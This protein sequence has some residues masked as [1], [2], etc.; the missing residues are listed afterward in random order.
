MTLVLTGHF[1][2]DHGGVERFSL[3]L[4]KRLPPDRIV[5]VAP[6]VS[7]AAEFDDGLDFPVV[8]YRGR[9]T[10]NPRLTATITATM[11]RF[12]CEQAWLT[13]GMPLG[14]MAGVVRRGGA[15]RVVI[16]THGL[17]AGWAALPGVRQLMQLA[18]RQADVLTYLTPYTRTRLSPLIEPDR[19][20]QLT[21]GADADQPPAAADGAALRERL[22][23]DGR[24][25]VVSVSRLV[26]RKGQDML[27]HAWGQLRSA[28]P[29]AALLI[30]G[31][32]YYGRQLRRLARRLGVAD[33]VMFVG[34]VRDDELPSYLAAADVYA[35][36]CRTQLGGMLV[37][38]LGLTTLEA[39]A[40]GLPV[41]VGDSGGAAEAV[42]DGVTGR[43]VPTRRRRKGWDVPGLAGVLDELLGDAA[44]R[45]AMGAA[46]RD[47]VREC[48]SWDAMAG[49]LGALLCG[50]PVRR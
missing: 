26:P 31:D 3:E 6:D 14:A 40:Q 49:R 12:D 27:L 42:I 37:E 50:A 15:R 39:S 24:P 35:L 16:S 46:G 9:V 45:A 21:G 36:P 5:V 38:G 41:V 10:T 20:V 23:L 11:R 32:G 2:P 8:R 1:P 43:V 29:G 22:G 13:S 7:G 47:W 44:L 19:L 25:V 34:A 30:V 18:A 33:S 48:W 4:A 28:H 17:E